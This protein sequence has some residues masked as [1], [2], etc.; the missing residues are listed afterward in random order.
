M[1]NFEDILNGEFIGAKFLGGTEMANE[2]SSIIGQEVKFDDT[3]IS[4]GADEDE[5]DN[6]VMCALFDTD[7]CTI[8]VYYGDVTEEIG[9]VWVNET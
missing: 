6:Y 9:F 5:E 2:I 4:D 3:Y 8:R 7:Y 1:F